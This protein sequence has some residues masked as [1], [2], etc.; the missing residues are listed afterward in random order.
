MGGSGR[1]E[2]SKSYRHLLL[3]CSEL[4]LSREGQP[5]RNAKVAGE[6]NRALAG[7]R[8]QRVRLI[9]HRLLQS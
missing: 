6:E 7:Y 3:N 1:C 2:R 8:G 9:F 5:I 4:M